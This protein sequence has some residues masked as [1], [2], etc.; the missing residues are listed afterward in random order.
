MDAGE[1]DIR[2]AWDSP[3]FIVFDKGFRHPF[4]FV[5]KT[6]GSHVS[7]SKG[8]NMNYLVVGGSS[9]GGQSV[10][11][12]IRGLDSNSRIIATTSKEKEVEGADRTILGIDLSDATAAEQVIQSV[13]EAI[14]TM[15]FMP[16]YGPVGYPV[17]ETNDGDMKIALDFSYFPL[18]TLTEDLKPKLTIGFSAFYWLN[19]ISVAY[20]GMGSAKVA[21]EKLA[22]DQPKQYKVIRFGAFMSNS[23]RGI[24]LLTYRQLKTTKHPLLTALKEDYEQSDMRFPKYFQNYAH[25]QEKLCYEKQFSAPHRSTVTDDLTKAVTQVLKGEIEKPILNVIGDWV[26]QED[27]WPDFPEEWKRVANYVNRTVRS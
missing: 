17:S 3:K 25:T 11:A 6:A 21:L 13:S 5:L 16:A 8:L 26:W 18:V 1:Y 7:I 27:Q 14:D 19:H 24:S 4:G 10:I 12:A 22:F 9:V 15:F 20:G 2:I 23:L